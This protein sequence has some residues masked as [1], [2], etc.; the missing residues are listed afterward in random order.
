MVAWDN[1]SSDEPTHKLYP[2]AGIP[3]DASHGGLLLA[4]R[5]HPDNAYT[6][7]ARIVS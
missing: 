1:R 5:S 6:A 3:I 2:M 4:G 7:S